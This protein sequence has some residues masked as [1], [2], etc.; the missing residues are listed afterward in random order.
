MDRWSKLAKSTEQRG[1]KLVRVEAPHFWA[2]IILDEGQRCIKA[3]PSLNWTVG[4]HAI[5]LRMRFLQ[6]DW[7][8]S[9]IMP[10]GWRITF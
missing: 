1:C 10:D 9:E 2:G 7:G 8:A 6:R 5:E 3:T 4:K